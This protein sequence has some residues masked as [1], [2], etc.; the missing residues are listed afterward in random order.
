MPTSS[1]GLPLIS[2]VF[3]VELHPG[4][5][6]PHSLISPS[7]SEVTDSYRCGHQPLDLSS[8]VSHLRGLSN[9]RLH[10]RTLRVG[11][12]VSSSMYSSAA[13]LLVPL[14]VRSAH[15]TVGVAAAI[16]TL[17]DIAAVRPSV[18]CYTARLTLHHRS[19]TF[20]PTYPSLLSAYLRSVPLP[21]SCS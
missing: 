5:F 20:S 14:A 7:Q 16:Q 12:P 6:P 11:V 4:P 15:Q 9:C 21:S 2:F 17:S 18:S 19:N 1:S 3:P 10:D 13:A 8:P